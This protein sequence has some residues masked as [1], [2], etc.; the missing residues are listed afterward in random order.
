MAE[1]RGDSGWYA[2]AHEPKSAQ[3]AFGL[4]G[5]QCLGDTV[6]SDH[7]TAPPSRDKS[8]RRPLI[9]AI[10]VALER[11][12]SRLPRSAVKQPQPTNGVYIKRLLVDKKSILFSTSAVR[13]VCVRTSDAFFQMV[14][15]STIFSILSRL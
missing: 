9:R 14:T 4:S 10:N 5:R 15:K 11:Q 8:T 3:G 6:L 13:F 12:T 1:D 2:C 7:D